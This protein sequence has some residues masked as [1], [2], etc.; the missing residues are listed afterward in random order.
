MV[1]SYHK[2]AINPISH[3]C[4]FTILHHFLVA[5]GAHGAQ[6]PSSFSHPRIHSTA[7]TR[8]AS[9][10]PHVRTVQEDALRHVGHVD[11]VLRRALQRLR[12]LGRSSG[13]LSGQLV[14]KS[15]KTSA[16]S[17]KNIGKSN[18]IMGEYKGRYDFGVE[19]S[20]VW[21]TNC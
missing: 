5:H 15:W 8:C 21:H 1:T 12:C 17:W 18:E 10:K 2:S 20:H 16:K 11:G 7:T 19:N 3:C 6:K 9:S 14:E 13:N 4:W